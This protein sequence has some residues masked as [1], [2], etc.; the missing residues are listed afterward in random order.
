[1]IC[2]PFETG[3]ICEVNQGPNSILDIVV[4]AYIECQVLTMTKKMMAKFMGKSET[5]L[6]FALCMRIKK[7]NSVLIK[8]ES[9]EH[10]REYI[11]QIFEGKSLNPEAATL[12]LPR[13][14]L[15]KINRR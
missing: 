9:S 1:M 11:R 15:I 8:T 14:E 6:L 3:N 12:A 13:T 7:L 4:V 2:L 10:A 5:H